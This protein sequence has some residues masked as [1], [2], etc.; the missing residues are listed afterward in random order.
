MRFAKRQ[1]GSGTS[2]WSN[3]NSHKE[4]TRWRYHA[5]SHTGSGLGSLMRAQT[6][7]TKYNDNLSF[8]TCSVPAAYSPS[9]LPGSINVYRGVQVSENKLRG[10]E[11]QWHRLTNWTWKQSRKIQKKNSPV[12]TPAQKSKERDSLDSSYLNGLYPGHVPEELTN[13]IELSVIAKINTGTT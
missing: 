7:A 5:N 12:K 6:I 13:N 8:L 1:E 3:S 2:T 11:I 10:P 4:K 9:W